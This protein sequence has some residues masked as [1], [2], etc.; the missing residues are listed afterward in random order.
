MRSTRIG[1][2]PTLIT[3]API[4]TMTGRLCRWAFTMAW[5]T[6]RKVLTPGYPAGYREMCATSRR[7]ATACKVGELNLAVAPSQRIGL[8]IGHI[9]RRDSGGLGA[10][11][12]F[13]KEL[14]LDEF[15]QDVAERDVT[16]LN[17]GGHRRGDDE[18]IVHHAGQF[19]ARCRRSSQ[20]SSG[21]D[22]AP[23]PLP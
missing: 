1:L 11:R 3:C 16:F 21:P 5:A 14:F 23:R 4:P 19:S 10:V 9:D 15:A 12:R 20:S 18:G 8:E 22:H 7:A 17:P 2:S 6:A 13:A